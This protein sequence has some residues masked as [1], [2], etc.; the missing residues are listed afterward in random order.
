MTNLRLQTFKQFLL[1]WAKRF[2]S[3]LLFGKISKK[4]QMVHILEYKTF[5]KPY[6]F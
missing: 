4:S 6:Q 5:S 2:V 1:P 3:F